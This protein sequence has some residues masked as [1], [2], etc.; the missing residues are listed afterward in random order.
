[1]LSIWK[2]R[3]KASDGREIQKQL[4]G[5]NSVYPVILHRT[6]Q[7]HTVTDV[8]ALDPLPELGD[9]NS[10]KGCKF[11]LFPGGTGTWMGAHSTIILIRARNRTLAQHP[12][13]IP[14]LL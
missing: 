2:R 6:P 14:S 1:M 3:E 5:A 11:H 9:A 7:Q 8:T 13:L 4:K 10:L 12:D